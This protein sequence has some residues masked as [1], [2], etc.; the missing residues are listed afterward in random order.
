M[1]SFILRSIRK[2]LF[3]TIL[4]LLT[5]FL[6]DSLI[7]SIWYQAYS[8]SPL[9]SCFALKFYDNNTWVNSDVQY[10]S[11]VPGCSLI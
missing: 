8:H 10:N 6:P 3:I 11:N 7:F 9:Q 4:T 5:Q 2:I 1:I